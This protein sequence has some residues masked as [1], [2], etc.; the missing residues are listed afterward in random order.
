LSIAAALS[1]AALPGTAKSAKEYLVYVGTYTRGA[2]RG[3]YVC[4][5]NAATGK[6]S[7]PRLA[8]ATESPS[9]LAL[10]PS[11]RF[12][13]AVNEVD[14]FAGAKGGSVTAFAVD[15]RSGD[16]TQLNAVSSRGSGPCYVTV[17]P[18]GKNALVANYGSGSVAVLPIGSDGRLSEASAF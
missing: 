8:A 15:R 10:H 9:F 14:N 12:L 17:D 16:L 7:A 6:L 11:G 5:F 13:Y 18:T 3:I 2:S 1:F 4:R